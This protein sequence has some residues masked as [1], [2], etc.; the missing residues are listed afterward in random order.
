MYTHT[1]IF[2]PEQ[3]FSISLCVSFIFSLL[4]LVCLGHSLHRP[5]GLARLEASFPAPPGSPARWWFSR[6]DKVFP[7]FP[8]AASSNRAGSEHS[9]KSQKQVAKDHFSEYP[10]MYPGPRFKAA[11]K[12]GSWVKRWEKGPRTP[13]N[14]APSLRQVPTSREI[15]T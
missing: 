3:D 8:S 13:L 2:S 11:P 15:P 7:P 12:L 1:H 14:P 10:G 5:G 9:R 4:C 6:P